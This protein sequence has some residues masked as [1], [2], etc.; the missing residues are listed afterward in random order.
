MPQSISLEVPGT[1]SLP[2]SIILEP[3]P[4]PPVRPDK[5][6]E[7]PSF[8]ASTNPPVAT[9]VAAAA[10]YAAALPEPT[11]APKVFAGW[12]ADEALTKKV[13]ALPLYGC[14]LYAK[15][16]IPTTVTF[17]LDGGASTTMVYNGNVVNSP[18]DI[19]GER[20]VPNAFI[21]TKPNKK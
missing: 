4:I 19:L 2:V 8:P 14:T 21:V 13:E 10:D 7:N 9:A 16:E 20:Y 11:N 1:Q 17:N 12:F 5:P 3:E 6:S 18:S 15:W